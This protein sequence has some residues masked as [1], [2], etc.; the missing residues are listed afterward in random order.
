MKNTLLILLMLIPGLLSA[1]TSSPSETEPVAMPAN[2]R[3]LSLDFEKSFFKPSESARWT[4]SISAD[5]PAK[6]ILVTTI[7]SLDRQLAQTRDELDLSPGTVEIQHAWQPPA[8]SPR[9][10]GL[11][12]RLETPQ[13][14]L[15]N[16][17][18]SAFDVLT[19]WTQNPRYGFM[20]DF[21]PNRADGA[22]AIE[23][24][25]RYHI[26]G[27]QFYDWMYRHDTY[28]PPQDTFT[29]PLGRQLSLS[30]TRDLISLAH[31][32]GMA[33]MPYTAVYAASIPFFESHRDWALFE[34]GGDP[35]FFGDNFLVIMD[36]RPG[37]PWTLHLLDQFGQILAQ[38]EFDGIHLD[39][40]GA[41]QK[42]Y[43]AQGHS[44]ELDQPLADL[45][46]ST[47]A[48]V[49]EARGREGAVIFNAVTNWPIETV[50]PSK[51]S[52]VYIEVWPPYTGFNDL[53]SLIRRAQNLGGGK[54]V[55]IAAYI[56]PAYET[57]ARL[58]DAIIFA[59][60]AGHIELGEQGGYL[61]DPY[62]PKYEMPSAG[63]SEALV[64]YYEF[65]IRYQGV[66]GPS[67][68]SE[69][70]PAGSSVAIEGVKT[71]PALPTDKVMVIERV[72][73]THAALS[74]VNM[75]GLEH[76]EWEKE[77]KSP[78]TPLRDTEVKIKDVTRQAAKIWFATPDREDISL[79]PLDF[80]QDGETITLTLPS[81]D[82]WSLILIE[83]SSQS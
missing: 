64:R 52:V 24:L 50:A 35:S 7:T 56:H 55:V 3:L 12:I 58:N 69:Q 25:K 42:G 45:I 19:V 11:D 1:C 15:I 71:T 78:P 77:L 66:L 67:A 48:V 27:L 49:E 80:R 36:P 10:Y 22:Q 46:D 74:L 21:A 5:A 61:A 63:L 47:A 39:Q 28:L 54:P 82:Y 43:D 62:F 31:L 26:N 23:T 6:V 51:E 37:S 60:G 2:I 70:K 9:G 76:G 79:Q 73:G 65:A 68:L 20:T 40:Y 57:N 17:I 8:E 72:T 14:E 59:S 32:N 34:S 33:A 41:P 13:G 29:D 75:V 81:L 18:F 4:V 44:Y 83:W 53:N 30:T 16:A 38:T